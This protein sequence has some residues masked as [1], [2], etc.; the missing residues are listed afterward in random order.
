MNH[1]SKKGVTS[2]KKKKAN[3]KLDVVI[4]PYNPS[5]LRDR[6]RRNMVQSQPRQKVG[7]TLSQKTSQVW[8]FIPVIPAMGMHR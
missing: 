4:C 7:K 1:G 8:W 2:K 6:G 5:Y 3:A